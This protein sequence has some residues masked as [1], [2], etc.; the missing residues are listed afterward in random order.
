LVREWQE[1]Y[2][3]AELHRERYEYEYDDYG[4]PIPS[5][6]EPERTV[7]DDCYAEVYLPGAFL[8][9]EKQVQLPS[10]NQWQDSVT[11][12][13]NN[14]LTY[15]IRVSNIGS[16]S[17]SNFQ[18]VD[19]LRHLI[20]SRITN[21]G[22]FTVDCEYS[23]YSFENGVL[24][25]VIPYL[26]VEDEI[27]ITFQ[28]TVVPQAAG[29]TFTN[30]AI[31]TDEN[32]EQLYNY[33]R[34]PETG[35][36]ERVTNE[37]GSSTLRDSS[38]VTVPTPP[39]PNGTPP[40]GTPPVTPPN[41]G[42]NGDNGGNGGNGGDGRGNWR[43]RPPATTPIPPTEP[44]QAQ[45]PPTPPSVPAPPFVPSVPTPPQYTPDVPD[46]VIPP[47]TDDP[48]EPYEPQDP[49]RPN[50]QTG[51]ALNVDALV[52]TMILIA[53]AFAA[54]LVLVKLVIQEEVEKTMKTITEATRMTLKT[55]ELQQ[56]YLERHQYRRQYQNQHRYEH[57][58]RYRYLH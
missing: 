16:A 42:G 1:F 53:L 25:V 8:A 44:P 46:E 35:E 45:Q 56:P 24:T 22:N 26:G 21:V 52:L 51:D 5:T 4:V 39:P 31:L 58:Y 38:N 33:S 47:T 49:N 7:V 27:I 48:S 6:R 9:I 29:T 19:D 55:V 34:N 17:V 41:G 50:P 28:A 40:N 43:P 32:G 37:D 11:A 18:M 2:N 23:E 36:L 13:V 12:Q 30:T 20:T 54:L 10:S 57:Q 14:I 3:R 15:R